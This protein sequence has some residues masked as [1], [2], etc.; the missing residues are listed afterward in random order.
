MATIEQTV[1]PSPG[2]ARPMAARTPSATVFGLWTVCSC[3]V[4][5]D[6]VASSPAAG[7][8]PTTLHAGDISRAAGKR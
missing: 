4:R 1:G 6:R 7:S 2:A 8:T 5:N 3:F